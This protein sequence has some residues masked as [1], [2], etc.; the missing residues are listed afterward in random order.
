MMTPEQT[1]LL[2]KLQLIRH[3]AFTG[4]NPLTMSQDEAG[5]YFKQNLPILEYQKALAVKP[6]RTF[7]EKT[8]WGMNEYD[9]RKQ[10]DRWI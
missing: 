10:V 7:E 4:I 1:R 9:C 2:N 8:F 3:P 6:D 5:D